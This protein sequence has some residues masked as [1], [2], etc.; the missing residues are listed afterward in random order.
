MDTTDVREAARNA[1]N[2]SKSFVTR[3]VDERTRQIG[4]QIGSTARDLRKVGDDLRR[5]STL[6]P[7]ADYADQGATLVDRL[8]S[9]LA[10]ADS[11]RLLGDLENLARRQPWAI[12]AGAAALG[13]AGSRF[14]K[15]SSARRYR[16][17][18]GELGAETTAPYGAVN[19]PY[20]SPAGYGGQTYAT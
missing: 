16:S 15:T 8:A 6:S 10:E 18:M 1:V 12:A 4:E 7:L 2:Q 17:S 3:L 9:Y 19:A 20:G 13:F 14:L 11:E 5:S